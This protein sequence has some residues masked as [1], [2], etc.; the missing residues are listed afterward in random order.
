MALPGM[1]TCSRSRRH[2]AEPAALPVRHTGGGRRAQLS[3]NRP[4]SRGL[5]H[6]PHD[7]LRARHAG[8]GEFLRPHRHRRAAPD[9]RRPYRRGATRQRGLMDASAIRRRDRG[10]PAL[11]P[12]RRRHEGRD[13]G[14]HRRHA[15]L[16]RRQ[17]RQAARGRQRLDLVPDHRRRGERRDQRHAEA[18]RLGREARRDLRS[19]HS[20][21]AEQPRNARRHHQDRPARLAERHADRARQAGPRRLSRARRQSGHRSGRADLGAEGRAARQR[22]RSCSIRPISNSSRSISA[23]RPSI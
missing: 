1:T 4:E 14:L 6:P 9:V 8:R 7:L 13:R 3:R 10:R 22:L 5:H 20:R 17:R 11:R 2:R 23:T 21:R 18:A 12:R 15:R 16:S 19:L